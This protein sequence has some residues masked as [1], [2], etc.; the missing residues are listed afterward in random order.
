[1]VSKLTRSKLQQLLATQPTYQ[2]S[3]P[4]LA[5]ARTIKVLCFVGASCMGKTTV[6]DA[7]VASNKD[8]G[9]TRNFTSRPP[10]NEDDQK[11]YY[12]F[13]HSDEGLQPIFSHIE[14]R[15]LLQYNINPFSLYV[16]GSE[17]SGYPYRYN[18]ADIFASSISDFRNL[19][20]K[21]L[22]VFSLVSPAEVW[23]RRFQI[24]FTP[25]NPQ[26][27]ARLQEAE[28]SL[29]WSLDQKDNDHCLLLNDTTPENVATS[30]VTCLQ[31]ETLAQAQA[32]KHAQ[33]CLKLVRDLL[34]Q[35]N[36]I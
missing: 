33:E 35:N 17:V 3:S 28:Q 15:E 20:F 21:K 30:V 27:V 7:L 5:Q 26:Y 9:K 23:L 2:P 19:E 11:R 13:E 10:R 22:D 14:N 12:Y 24:R 29:L 4:V 32:R 1:M 34:S 8:F 31:G 6:M 25:D 16:Y 36:H 18:L